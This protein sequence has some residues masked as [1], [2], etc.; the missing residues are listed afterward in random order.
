MAEPLAMRFRVTAQGAV[1]VSL[2]GELRVGP[3][4][5]LRAEGEFAGQR[6]DL[7]LWTEGDRLL[8]GP[9]DALAID[10]PRPGDLESSLLLGLTRMGVLHNLAMLSGGAAPDHAERWDD[11]WVQVTEFHRPSSMPTSGDVLEFSLVV[12]GEPSGHASLW[13]DDDGVPLRREQVVEFPDGTMRVEEHYEVLESALV[14]G[15]G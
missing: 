8:A 10:Q 3:Q 14:P 4:V 12:A 6:Q 9:P 11:R 5:V 1:R 7:H 2:A 13:L 15:A